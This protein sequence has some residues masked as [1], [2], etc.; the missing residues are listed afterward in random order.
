[1]F[2]LR[3]RFAVVFA[4]AALGEEPVDACKHIRW[5]HALLLL[6]DAASGVMSPISF[7]PVM[8]EAERHCHSRTAERHCDHA[9]A[10]V[11]PSSRTISVGAARRCR[12]SRRDL[13]VG[14]LHQLADTSK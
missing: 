12:A 11:V 4:A 5:R 14:E 2:E 1:M 13:P 6:L 9:S 8:G 10:V 7:P 3:D